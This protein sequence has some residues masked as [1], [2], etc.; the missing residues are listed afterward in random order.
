MLFFLSAKLSDIDL[1]IMINLKKKFGCY[2]GLSDHTQGLDVS[3]AAIT[4][5]AKYIE[6]H[7]T[8]NKLSRGPD[9]KTSINFNELKTLI[10]KNDLIYQ[11]FKTGKKNV[12]KSRIRK[13]QSCKKI[14]SCQEKKLKGK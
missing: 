6:K 14:T 4:L 3:L 10:S 2:V 8:L 11:L 1:N 5:G 7:F 9:H 13:S 12:L